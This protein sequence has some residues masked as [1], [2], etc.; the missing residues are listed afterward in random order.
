MPRD[1]PLHTQ[2]FQD[3]GKLADFAVEL[4]ISGVRESPVLLQIKAALFLRQV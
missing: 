1:R 2:L 3:I 4:G